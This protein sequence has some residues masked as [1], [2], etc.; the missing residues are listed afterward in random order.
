MIIYNKNN[1]H[2]ENSYQFQDK[3]KIR[4]EVSWIMDIRDGRRLPVTRSEKSYVREWLGHNKLYNLGLFKSHTKDVDLDEYVGVKGKL[5]GFINEL[6][7][8]LIGR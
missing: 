2:V 7:W 1:T 4:S 3:N 6:I 5:K 8:L